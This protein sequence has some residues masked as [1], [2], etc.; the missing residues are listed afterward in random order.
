MSERIS[1]GQKSRGLVRTDA[2]V[3]GRRR[4][5]VGLR[6]RVVPGSG[7]AVADGAR[8]LRKNDVTNKSGIGDDPHGLGVEVH[9]VEVDCDQLV[10]AKNAELN[11]QKVWHN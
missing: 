5:R 8:L 6:V 3:N 9:E 10:T 2:D 11:I 4:R 1:G 7:D